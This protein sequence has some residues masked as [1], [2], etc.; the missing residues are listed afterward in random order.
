MDD[1]YKNIEEYN[2][3]KK[4]EILIIFDD[5]T[6]DMFNDKKLSPIVIELLIRRM[7]LNISLVFITQSYFTV[8]KNS[9][10]N[11]TLFFAKKFSNKRNKFR[12]II[13]QIFNS[14]TLLIFTKNVLQ[15]H[16]PS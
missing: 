12:I 6:T 2:P 3:N 4:Q 8:P 14:K 13:H 10:R 9:R 5:M 11:S 7:K 1:V 15:N 16:I